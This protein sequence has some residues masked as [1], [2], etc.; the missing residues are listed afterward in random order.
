MHPGVVEPRCLNEHSTI[1][2]LEDLP[3]AI[4]TVTR[5]GILTILPVYG[6][7]ALSCAVMRRTLLEMRGW[8]RWVGVMNKKQN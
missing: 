1:D 5:S 3:R 8:R 6:V 7:I 4:I 2:T